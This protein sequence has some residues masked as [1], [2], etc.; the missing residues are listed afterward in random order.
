[1]AG[2]RRA[3][4]VRSADGPDTDRA[5]PLLNGVTKPFL[6]LPLAEPIPAPR[7]MRLGVELGVWT[8]MRFGS[9]ITGVDMALANVFVIVASGTLDGVEGR[10]GALKLLGRVGRGAVKLGD[11]RRL[12]RGAEKEGDEGR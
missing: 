9:F 7:P 4:G 1:M 5:P 3:I 2:L 10:T 6:D 8:L 11:G 12:G